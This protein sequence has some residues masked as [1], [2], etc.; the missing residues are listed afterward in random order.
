MIE[1]DRKRLELYMYEVLKTKYKDIVVHVE[2]FNYE[3]MIVCFWNRR[4]IVFYKNAKT[5]TF[6]QN[7]FDAVMENEIRPFFGVT[8]SISYN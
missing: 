7:E 6:N 4:S 3:V 1:S 5:F 8:E 2:Q